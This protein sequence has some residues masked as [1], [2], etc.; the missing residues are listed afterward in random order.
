MAEKGRYVSYEEMLARWADRPSITGTPSLIE[1]T[2]DRF[3]RQVRPEV[4]LN[5]PHYKGWPSMKRIESKQ[6]EVRLVNRKSCGV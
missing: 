4:D 2:T 1:R 5:F 6:A 3:V